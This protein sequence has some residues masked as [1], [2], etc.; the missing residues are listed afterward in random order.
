MLVNCQSNLLKKAQA[1]LTILLF[2]G[3]LAALPGQPVSAQSIESQFAV[4]KLEAPAFIDDNFR[5]ALAGAASTINKTLVQPDGKI[6]VA[7]NFHLMSGASKNYIARFNPDG[8]LD[9]SFNAKSG[10]NGIISAIG[11]QSDGKIIVGGSFTSYS[12]NTVGNIARLNPD[13]TFDVTF[14]SSGIYYTAGASSSISDISVMPDNRFYIVGNF[15]SY[16]GTT[17]INRLARLN[18]NGNIDTTFVPGTAANSTVN[19][20]RQASGG[21]ILIGGFFTSYNG[22]AIKS[23]ARINGDGS[24]DTSFVIGTGPS[25]G[26]NTIAV[27]PDDK[28]LVGGSISTFN[29]AA[30]NGLALLNTD[31]SNDNTFAVTGTGATINAIARQSDGKWVVGGSFNAIGGTTRRSIARLNADGSFDA[32]FDAGTGLNT[33]GDPAAGL[34]KDLA[35]QADGSVILV[36]AFSSYNGTTR[37]GIARTNS[38]GSLDAGLAPT[39]M[40]AGNIYAISRQT[41]GKVLIGGSFTSVGGTARSN[42]ARLNADGSL[43]TSFVTGTG[44]NSLVESLA[45][46]PDGKIIIGGEFTSYNG[47]AMKGIARLNS[48][49]SLDTSFVVG[50]GAEGGVFTIALQT[51]GKVLIG[52]VITTFN[53]V[54]VNNIAR[55]NTDGSLDSSFATGTGVNATVRKVIVQPDGKVLVGGE[56]STF[57]AAPKTRLMR[58]NADGS[59]DASFVT[60]T[61][62]AAVK[63]VIRHDDGKIVIV[64][65]FTT[66]NGTPR[67]R[68]A[69]LNADGSLDTTFDPGVGFTQDVLAITALPDGKYMV[70]GSFT[71]ASG[72]PRNRIARLRANGSLDPKFLS[73]LGA[74]GTGSSQIRTIVPHNGKYL[75]GGQFETYNTSARS[76]L[77]LMKNTSKVPVDFDGDG[78]TDVSIARHDGG[79]GPW[80]W[81]IKYSSNDEVLN[82]DYGIFTVDG[83]QPGDFDGDGRADIAVW[84][85]RAAVDSPCGYWITFSSTNQTKFIQYGQEGDRN[86]LEDYDG[87]GKDDMAIYRAPDTTVGPGTWIYRGSFNNPNGNLT[88]VPFGM[89]YGDQAD[90]TDD[91][92]PGDFDGDG[93]ADFRVQRRLDTSVLTSSTPAIFY[94]LTAAGQ[95]SYDYFGHASDRTIP[96]DYDGDGKTDMA[97]SRGFNITCASCVTT[98]YIRYTGGAPDAQFVWGAGG[99]DNFVQGDYD[100]D[101]TTDVAV[102]RRAGE[103]N[104]YIKRSSDQ[105]T[106]VLQ[107]GAAVEPGGPASDVPIAVYNNR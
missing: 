6:L 14:N 37:T 24:L 19:V 51:D 83:L 26:I 38:S 94:T 80:H 95:F 85:G 88:Y 3:F 54:V 13:G 16:N 2:L 36:G 58:L 98:W 17:G 46:Q 48:D 29:T 49:G 99:L 1:Y 63:D 69:R 57:N 62:N 106:M 5:P 97:I 40:L 93:R 64:G 100:G 32:T 41:D 89:R 27:L 4:D 55:L 7:G 56:F 47:T 15:T 11:L 44:A 73:G 104:Y 84:R 71:T 18:P 78:I 43:D 39:S 68:A 74:L 67:N 8:T 10:A 105:A 75:I 45:V 81:W 96:G 52:G 28:V 42:V 20:V 66:V 76:G 72:L 101:G 92:Y 82:F 86:V 65:S 25:G 31:G 23:L 60:G 35:L 33:V 91:L 21:K 12:G 102:Y 9:Q 61:I 53:S 34:I 50:T 79:I 103:N 30:K 90:Q 59:S 107:W 77:L 70:G 87:D 22:T